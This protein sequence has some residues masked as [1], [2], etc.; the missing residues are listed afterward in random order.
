VT[1]E[2]DRLLGQGP[3]EVPEPATAGLPGPVASVPKKSLGRVG[4]ALVLAAAALVL[5]GMTTAHSLGPATFIAVW[6]LI[7]LAQLFRRRW[8]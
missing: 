1:T 5:V 3:R 2:Q 4:R 6:V 8:R 7:G